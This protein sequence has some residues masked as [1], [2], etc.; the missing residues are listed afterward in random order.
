MKR[1]YT[2]SDINTVKTLLETPAKLG[3]IS[4]SSV[5]EILTALKIYLKGNDSKPKFM[6]PTEVAKYLGV[7]TRYI[8]VLA[9]QGF[10]KKRQFGKRT[11]R[12]LESDVIALAMGKQFR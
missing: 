5:K 11:T 7:S 1:V 10:I 2:N 4:N 8:D 3:L 6:K 12:Y 9:R